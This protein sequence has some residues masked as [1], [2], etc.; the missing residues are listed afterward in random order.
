MDWKWLKDRY[1]N[2]IISSE[3]YGRSISWDKLNYPAVI[4]C[5]VKID[6]LLAVL[7]FYTVSNPLNKNELTISGWTETLISS[8]F[9]FILFSTAL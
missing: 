2:W 3:Y 7:D 4:E 9:N 5:S 6:T 8:K 1:C